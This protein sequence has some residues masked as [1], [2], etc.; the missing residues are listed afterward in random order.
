MRGPYVCVHVCVSAQV[1]KRYVPP[2]QRSILVHVQYKYRRKKTTTENLE[3][4][5]LVFGQATQ[6]CVLG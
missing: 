2:E 1:L 6:P 3:A 5:R 4:A